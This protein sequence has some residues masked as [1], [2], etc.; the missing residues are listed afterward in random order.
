MIVNWD[1]VKIVPVQS[2]NSVNFNDNIKDQKVE[3]YELTKESKV[4][5]E[6]IDGS[7]KILTADKYFELSSLHNNTPRPDTI[8]SQIIKVD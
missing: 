7:Q 1:E 8:I 4:T 6:F 5:V 3:Y 2:I